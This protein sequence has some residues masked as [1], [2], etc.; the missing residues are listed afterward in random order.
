MRQFCQNRSWSAAAILDSKYNDSCYIWRVW[1]QNAIKT[2]VKNCVTPAKT[3]T[4]D[5]KIQ[6]RFH[7]FAKCDVH[8]W[9]I[10]FCKQMEAGLYL[11]VYCRCFRGSNS[12][13]SLWRL[14]RF[15]TKLFKCRHLI[16]F[17]KNQEIQYN[18]ESPDS[19]DTF[20]CEI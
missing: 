18:T 2:K 13:F 6:P 8:V 10:A 20:N 3:S 19:I 7:L 4:I 17:S 14:S 16:L 15:V 1:S 5:R 11:P 9:Y 12:I